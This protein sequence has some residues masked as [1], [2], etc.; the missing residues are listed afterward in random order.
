MAACQH[1]R[2]RTRGRRSEERRRDARRGRSR[3]MLLCTIHYLYHAITGCCRTAAADFFNT[4]A[5][6][7][8]HLISHPLPACLPAC[9]AG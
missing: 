3:V 9:P 7:V 6:V 1:S 2:R 5:R 4:R 8:F